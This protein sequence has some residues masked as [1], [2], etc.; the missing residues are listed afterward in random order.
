VNA[1]YTSG[2]ETHKASLN[3][4]IRL[5]Y[6]FPTLLITCILAE[7]FSITHF[8]GFYPTYFSSVLDSPIFFLV[9]L[10]A[11]V[12]GGLFKNFVNVLQFGLSC[13]MLARAE[14]KEA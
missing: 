5:Y 6:S 8:M 9:K 1:S 4:V 10:A 7:L 11:L 12:G 14:L 3:P 2:G 13:Q